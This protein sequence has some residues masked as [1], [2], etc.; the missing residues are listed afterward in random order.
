LLLCG[1][2]GV[3]KTTMAKLIAGTVG[4]DEWAT[5]EL[6][7]SSCD[8][9]SVRAL[10]RSIGL[11]TLTASGSG[12]RVWIVNECH[13][14]SRESI[15]VWLTLLEKLPARRLVIFTTTQDP[16]E[17]LF[18]EFSDPFAGRCMVF[19]F[20]SQGL[21]PAFA[22]R[23]HDIAEIE[24]LNGKPLAQYVRMVGDCHNSFRQA[25]ERVEALEM[26]DGPDMAEATA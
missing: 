12:W 25:L 10:E 11:T 19:R 8:K 5:T 1:P 3:G 6:D 18:G 4:A 13:A 7:G 21:C 26:A 23:V 15:Q 17:N 24:G 22:R 20:T 9:E 2:S 16:K 14:M